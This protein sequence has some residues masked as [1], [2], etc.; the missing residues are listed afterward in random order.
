MKGD[1]KKLKKVCDKIYFQTTIL[2]GLDTY[3]DDKEYEDDPEG[4]DWVIDSLQQSQME[5]ESILNC[6]EDDQERYRK[7]QTNKNKKQK[8]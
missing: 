2:M 1:F 8:K 7:Q 5:I 6:L 4:F 3:T